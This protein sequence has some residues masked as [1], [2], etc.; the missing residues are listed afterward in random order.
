ME[1]TQRESSRLLDGKGWRGH[2][3]KLG[4]G[5]SQLPSGPCSPAV[6]GSAAVSVQS[7]VTSAVEEVTVR[8]REEQGKAGWLAVLPRSTRLEA[9]SAGER[10]PYGVE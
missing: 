10:V 3:G 5:H 6:P 8:Q 1:L 7:R 4:S 9:G 2:R